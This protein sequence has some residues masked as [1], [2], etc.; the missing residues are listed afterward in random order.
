MKRI[1]FPIVLVFCINWFTS[2]QI[3]QYE[4]VKGDKSLGKMQAHRFMNEGKEH[5]F[6]KSDVA[7][8]ILFSFEVAYEQEEIFVNDTLVTGYGFNELNGSVQKSTELQKEGNKYQL[9]INGVHAHLN[10]PSIIASMSQI[11]FREPSDGSSYFSQHFG[12]FVTFEKVGEGQYIME[13]PDGQNT[14]T[15][16]NGFCT[17]IKVSRDYGTYYFKMQP[18]TLAR[19]KNTA[20]TLFHK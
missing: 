1:L 10:D 18:E 14:Y 6:I 7:F 17:E 4:V 8:K 20:D 15:Y 5:Y 11:H 13:S 2:A 19:V 16:K 9:K 3:L 12:R